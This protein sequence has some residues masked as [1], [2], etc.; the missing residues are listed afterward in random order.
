MKTEV[1]HS[2]EIRYIFCLRGVKDHK[3]TSGNPRR[4]T[5]KSVYFFLAYVQFLIHGLV[6]YFTMPF[7]LWNLYYVARAGLPLV[8]TQLF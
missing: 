7:L 1:G 5:G 4:K 2:S 6:A 8:I 3:T